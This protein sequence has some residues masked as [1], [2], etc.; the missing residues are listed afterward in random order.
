VWKAGVNTLQRGG[1]YPSHIILPVA[2]A[3]SPRLPKPDLKPS[4][5]PLQT[6]GE[7]PKQEH[8]ITHDWVNQTTTVHLKSTRI[9]KS[10]NGRTENREITES[11]FTV[12]QANP[13]D[14]V[15]KANHE[16]LMIRPE[17]EYHVEADESVVSDAD[18]F[19]YLSEVHVTVNGK[20]H[21]NKS[22]NV[23]VPRKL[24]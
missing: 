24:N 13:A 1:D 17:G 19:R 9:E 7:I 15:L 11:T 10:D 12:S 14:A 16:F 6:P 22:W 2:P 8:R 21:F 20:P 3:Q 4:P 23:T 18:S 5:R